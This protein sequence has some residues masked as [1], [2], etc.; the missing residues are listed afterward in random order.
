M[1][2][3]KQEVWQ[4]MKKII[5]ESQK[6]IELFHNSPCCYCRKAV[7]LK[8]GTNMKQLEYLWNINNSMEATDRQSL[9]QREFTLEELSK[10][11]GKDGSM[12]YV[13]VNGTVYDVSG[14]AAWAGASHFGL[15]A[16]KD[17]TGAF[18]SC[19]ADQSVLGKLPVVGKLI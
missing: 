14:V 7:L 1:V 12:A 11:T 2:E 15:T 13:A 18:T 17:V 3:S 16:G 19:H 9:R 10:Y 6:Q 4:R 5:G 8:L